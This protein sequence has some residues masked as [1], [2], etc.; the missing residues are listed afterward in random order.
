MAK[1]KNNATPPSDL[2]RTECGTCGKGT[3]RPTRV[4]NHKTFVHGYPFTVPEAWFGV[5][6]ACGARETTAA[7]IKRWKALF[8]A[9]ETADR[10]WDQLYLF[11][12]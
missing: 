10:Q 3:A 2:T 1:K 4:L 9:Q 11:D 12:A 8:Q 5:C 7:E 6:D